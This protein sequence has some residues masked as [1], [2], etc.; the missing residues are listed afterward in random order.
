MWEKWD[1]LK[2][3]LLYTNEPEFPE[4][5]NKTVSHSKT[6]KRFSNL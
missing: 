5:E 1:E 4:F 2:N 3:K 6:L